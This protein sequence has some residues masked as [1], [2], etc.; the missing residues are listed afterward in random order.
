VEKSRNK[1]E[2]R[3]VLYILEF[4]KPIIEL[5]KKID[6][7]REYAQVGNVDMSE[8]IGKLETRCE[9]LKKDV[10]SNLSRWQRVQLA[11][12]P[13]RPY[14]LDFA[15]RI[16]S[17]FVEIHGDRLYGD[18]KAIIGGL[19]TIGNRNVILIGHQKGRGTKNNLYRNFGMPNPEGYRKALRIMKLA[20]KFN[21]PIVTLIDTPGAFP[22]KGSEER[23]IAEAIARNLYELSLFPV[24]IICVITGEGGSGGA[25]AIALGDRMFMLENSIFSVISPE[26]CAS[27]LLRDAAKAA[28]MAD[29]LKVTAIDLQELGIIDGIIKEPIGGAHRNYDE[30]AMT[31]KR[32]ILSAL[33]D[34]EI[35]SPE[36]LVHQRSEKFGKMGEWIEPR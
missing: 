26:G 12:H 22:G 23:G 17:S 30:T 4:E 32:T 33:N 28:Q 35:Y 5:E 11:R 10:Y 16:C 18:D 1:P 8:E 15:K 25:L 2:Q 27:I 9:K 13:E 20:V 21:K 34:L 14:T 6:E 29:S 36:E 7:M 3:I 19:A 24:P 31:L